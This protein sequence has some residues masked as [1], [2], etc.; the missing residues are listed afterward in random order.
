MQAGVKVTLRCINTSIRTVIAGGLNGSCD[1][2][3][4]A[5]LFDYLKD[6]APRAAG[7]RTAGPCGRRVDPQDPQPLSALAAFVGTDAQ[8]I[9]SLTAENSPGKAFPAAE[10]GYING[11]FSRSQVLLPAGLTLRA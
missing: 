5:R 9:M 2:I 4:S 7:A 1:L 3:Y 11:V 10:S 6:R 8:C